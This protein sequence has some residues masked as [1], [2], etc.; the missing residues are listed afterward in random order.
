[1]LKAKSIKPKVFLH[2]TKQ[3]YALSSRTEKL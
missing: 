3:L 1:M 2:I